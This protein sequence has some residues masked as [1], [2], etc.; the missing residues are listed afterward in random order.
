[1]KHKFK[2]QLYTFLVLFA[3]CGQAFSQITFTSPPPVSPRNFGLLTDEP[4]AGSYATGLGQAVTAIIGGADAI[5]YNPAGLAN[6]KKAT[7]ITFT[8]G[9]HY[10]L[11]EYNIQNQKSFTYLQDRAAFKTYADQFAMFFP[12]H[13]GPDRQVTMGFGFGYRKISPDFEYGDTQKDSTFSTKYTYK[14]TG[15]PSISSF[16]FGIKSFNGFAFGFSYNQIAGSFKGTTTVESTIGGVTSEYNSITSLSN[17]T[18]YSGSYWEFGTQ[19][20]PHQLVSLGL[21]IRLPH[22]QKQVNDDNNSQSR[23]LA[24]PYTY[25]AGL[26]IH[27]NEKTKVMLDYKNEDWSKV[28]ERGINDDKDIGKTDSLAKMAHYASIGLHAGVGIF[29]YRFRQNPY[30]DADN[31][32]IYTHALSFGFITKS[33]SKFHM[34]ASIEYTPEYAQKIDGVIR[35]PKN[36]ASPTSIDF[37]AS[38]FAFLVKMGCTIGFKSRKYGSSY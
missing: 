3:W 17:V 12:L 9:G 23:I 7:E 28:K 27:I 33:H 38:Q 21:K 25:S 29:A 18:A 5:Y 6:S 13:L 34:A 20:Q 2:L 24:I 37:K 15:S 32:S 10:G 16:G 1:M 22:D 19:I 30:N 14:G 35:V 31:K 8:I 4:A 11:S 26:A 36:P